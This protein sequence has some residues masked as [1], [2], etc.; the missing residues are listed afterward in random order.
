[1]RNSRSMEEKISLRLF[2][3]GLVGLVLTAALC[4]F[5]FHKAVSEQIWNRYRFCPHSVRC[6][7]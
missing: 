4:I 6:R 2:F 1:M 5:V 3:M 7:R